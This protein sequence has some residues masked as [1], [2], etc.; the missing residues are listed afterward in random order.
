MKFWTSALLLGTAAVV[1]A[2]PA[3]RPGPANRL[4]RLPGDDKPKPDP[5]AT[6]M[7]ANARAARALWD[8]F[9][10]FQA[11]VTVNIEGKVTRGTVKVDSK[12][13][14]D[15]DLTD[16]A[17]RD[18]AK[19]VLQSVVSHRLDDNPDKVVPCVFGDL[20]PKKE[21]ERQKKLR[22]V[23][24]KIR[25]LNQADSRSQAHARAVKVKIEAMSAQYLIVVQQKGAG[26][27]PAK[28]L[29]G[30]VTALQKE[31]NR[32]NDKLNRDRKALAGNL[33]QKKNLQRSAAVPDHPL[34]RLVRVL[35]APDGA[36]YRIKGR[37][38][39]VV[40]RDLEKAGIRLTINVLL[41]RFTKEKKFLPINVVVT[42]WDRKTRALRSTVAQRQT[43][44]RIGNFDLPDQILAT[45]SKEDATFE[46]RSLK[47]SNHQLTKKK[48]KDDKDDKDGKDDK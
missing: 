41:Y 29:K 28:Q 18:W 40:N 31:L 42:T 2:G 16:S 22:A 32:T 44:A 7:F 46:A 3:L 4:R 35:N 37:R 21:E 11:D 26:S 39:L 6:R 1:L 8:D 14:V 30:K 34:G 17:A 9:P 12:G 20:D 15:F 24:Q 45:T 36:S 27:K 48:K 47:L 23:E 5:A 33:A 25:A 38:I 13:K 43:W 10:G 19:G